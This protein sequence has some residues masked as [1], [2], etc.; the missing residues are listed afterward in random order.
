MHF[1]TTPSICTRKIFLWNFVHSMQCYHS[2]HHIHNFEVIICTNLEC[3]MKYSINTVWISTKI[4]CETHHL[5]YL[6]NYIPKASSTRKSIGNTQVFFSLHIYELVLNIAPKHDSSVR[7][8][9][10]SLTLCSGYTWQWT[11]SSQVIKTMARPLLDAK[12]LPEPMMTDV[13]LL[14]PQWGKMPHGMS[15]SCLAYK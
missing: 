10:N 15:C 13:I 4:F 12:S 8:H 9:F 2:M 11:G 3:S 7:L 6:H 14:K 1:F 5:L